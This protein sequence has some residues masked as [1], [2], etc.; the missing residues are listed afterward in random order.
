LL[1]TIIKAIDERLFDLCAAEGLGHVQQWIG[2]IESIFN[3]VSFEEDLEDGFA[4]F[5][6]REIDP[7]DSIEPP[8]PHDLHGER[9]DTVGGG[10][11][12]HPVSLGLEI[13]QKYTQHP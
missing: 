13:V 10:A 1:R 2:R 7:E 3:S 6:V 11:H 4:L 12:K 9:V 5:S 8:R